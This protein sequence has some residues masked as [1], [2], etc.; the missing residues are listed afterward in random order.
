VSAA[1]GIGADTF[2]TDMLVRQS[3]AGVEYSEQSVSMGKLDRMFDAATMAKAREAAA[4]D[5]HT[6]DLRFLAM[7][8]TD[9]VLSDSGGDVG[10][11]LEKLKTYLLRKDV[12]GV[13][14]AGPEMS[15]TAAGMANFEKV[16]RLVESVAS[17]RGRPLVLRPH[18]G[19]GYNPVGTGDHAKIAR[20]N[21][22]RLITTLER[23]G[24]QAGGNVVVRLGHAAHA[25]PGQLERLSA[26]GVIVESNVG[27]NLATGAIARAADHPIL[28]QAYL[29]VRTVLA[30]DGEGVM[31]TNVQ[32]EHRRAAM[33]FAE[34]R[35]GRIG[36]EVDGEVVH[37]ADIADAA[38]RERF[39]I[40]WI[41]QQ[42]QAYRDGVAAGDAH[43][44]GK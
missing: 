40:E 35:A 17:E 19:E 2:I 31:G 9:Q 29:G 42:S 21:L 30:T 27:S 23:I 22:E 25:T 7:L 43:D 11:T 20:Q 37:Y 39:S 36:L 1:G 10:G 18:V 32:A 12:A 34:F 41:D 15:F 14:I 8:R 6:A 13:D 4:A 16:Y 24:Y 26:L 28:Y 38:T 33:M 5:G 3:E 44:K